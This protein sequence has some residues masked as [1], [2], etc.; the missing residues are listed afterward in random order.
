MF[1]ADS[2]AD[3]AAASKAIGDAP[4]AP[5]ALLAPLS[6]LGT[7]SPLG[8]LG[9]LAQRG[10]ASAAGR[11]SSDRVSTAGE[12]YRKGT[13]GVFR[14]P[15]LRPEEQ[16]EALPGHLRARPP[17]RDDLHPCRDE[18]L[19]PNYRRPTLR[20]PRPQ[21][22]GLR[23]YS[24]TARRAWRVLGD[25]ATATGW[26]AARSRRGAD[27]R[28]RP[29]GGPAPAAIGATPRF[30]ARTTCCDTVAGPSN[31]PTLGRAAFSSPR[32]RGTRPCRLQRLCRTSGPLCRGP[33]S[34]GPRLGVRQAVPRPTAPGRAAKGRR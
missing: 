29:C 16:R 18:A 10:S 23:V 24:G 14:R 34:P 4:R 17:R 22:A 26:S 15:T 8:P 5:L 32:R 19:G 6:P 12:L 20:Q 33:E 21:R 13:F 2:L 3:H 11:T 31:E 9:P 1:A 27:S 25:A 30:L 28:G 7:L